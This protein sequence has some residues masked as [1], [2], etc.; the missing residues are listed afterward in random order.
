MEENGG[1]L[2]D[3]ETK[4]ARVKS[5]GRPVA[6]T[7]NRRSHQQD[8]TYHW[9]RTVESLPFDPM[10]NKA[11]G[12]IEDPD[13]RPYRE[14]IEGTGAS[15]CRDGAGNEPQ[16]R[17]AEPSVDQSPREQGDDAEK[18]QRA[19][20]VG[21]RSEESQAQH[22]RWRRERW[23]EGWRPKKNGCESTVVPDEV[24]YLSTTPT[25]VE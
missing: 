5:T 1:S 19:D 7:S 17:P 21:K 9:M 12:D 2:T 4:G 22:P 11:N 14:V 20:C 24:C 16:P 15:S 3:G 25:T 23:K 18:S 8:T 10:R 6:A 13:Q